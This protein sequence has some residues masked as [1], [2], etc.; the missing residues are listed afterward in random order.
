[1]AVPAFQCD[2]V[3][4]DQ[5]IRGVVEMSVAESSRHGDR[6]ERSESLNRIENRRIREPGNVSHPTELTG[7]EEVGAGQ[8]PAPPHPCAGP[9]GKTHPR[10]ATKAHLEGTV[11]QVIEG[12]AQLHLASSPAR[13]GFQA[14]GLQLLH[15]IRAAVERSAAEVLEKEIA[16]GPELLEVESSE[17]VADRFQAAVAEMVAPVRVRRFAHQQSGRDETAGGGMQ[18]EPGLVQSRYR[19]VLRV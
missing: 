16:L 8:K 6:G 17:N 9:G 2:L 14:G 11:G 1:M 12:V 10:E 5:N 18:V 15:V 3:A 13:H 7:A 4:V 19:R